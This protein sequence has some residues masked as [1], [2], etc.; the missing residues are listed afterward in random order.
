MRISIERKRLLEEPQA[1]KKRNTLQWK[2]KTE[3][4]IWGGRFAREKKKCGPLA[5][6]K[7]SRGKYLEK[8][9]LLACRA[10]IKPKAESPLREKANQKKR[11]KKK[12][13]KKK[14]KVPEM[15]RKKVRAYKR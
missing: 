9:K 13:E 15:K 2:E 12:K 8:E 3:A 10:P 6:R 5:D 14:K 1:R 7:K 4:Y 11:K